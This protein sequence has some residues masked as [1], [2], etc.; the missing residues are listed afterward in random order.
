MIESLDFER[1]V[2]TNPPQGVGV[3]G[4]RGRGSVSRG[5]I[6]I[7]IQCR[8]NFRI[9]PRK[10][11]VV[12]IRVCPGVCAIG[13]R[14]FFFALVPRGKSRRVR[15]VFVDHLPQVVIHPL[16]HV[17]LV[18][19]IS[20]PG[21]IPNERRIGV[22]KGVIGIPLHQHPFP[23]RHPAHEVAILSAIPR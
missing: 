21:E 15:G 16:P 6:K 1:L 19:K 8:T 4:S 7:R 3:G 13:I 14:S 22:S 17:G 23:V 20:Y 18:V 9:R 12:P 11:R 10:A 5:D 2:G